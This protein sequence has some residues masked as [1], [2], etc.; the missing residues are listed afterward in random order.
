M[1]EPTTTPEPNKELESLK[2]EVERLKPF[3]TQVTELSKLPEQLKTLQATHAT[4]LAERDAHAKKLTEYQPRLVEADKLP[5]VTKERDT[6][7][8]KYTGYI[9]KVLEVAGI[10]PELY[11]DK[12]LAE[13]EAMV[14]VAQAIK[15]TGTGLGLGAGLGTGGAGATPSGLDAE[16]AMLAKARGQK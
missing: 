3:E 9:S 4:V 5:V 10:K 12:S 6:L 8:G 14:T 11:K 1:P 7:M 16:K 13:L 2:A 15:P